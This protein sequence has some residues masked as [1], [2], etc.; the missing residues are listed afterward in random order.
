MVQSAPTSTTPSIV[1]SGPLHIE[2]GF[3]NVE[4]Y[5]RP[6]DYLLD[7]GH[8]LCGHPEKRNSSFQCWL[9]HTVFCERVRAISYV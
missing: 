4:L 7:H 6:V 2:C 5:I 8:Q 9:H 1:K 3:P